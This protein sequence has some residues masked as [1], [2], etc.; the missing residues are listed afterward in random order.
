HGDAGAPAGRRRAR[1]RRASAD[2]R[3]ARLLSRG[4]GRGAD[5]GDR[6]S[7]GLTATDIGLTRL[8]HKCVSMRASSSARRLQY[9]GPELTMTHVTILLGEDGAGMPYVLAERP[10]P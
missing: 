4:A 2:Q 7:L 6:E 8:I 10:R 9:P 5:R 3:P 1:A